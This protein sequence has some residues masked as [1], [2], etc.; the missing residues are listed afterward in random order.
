MFGTQKAVMI[1]IAVAVI[2]VVLVIGPLLPVLYQSFVDRALHQAGGQFTLENYV[3]LSQN[4]EFKEV[5]FN[6]LIFAAGSMVLAQVIGIFL[7]I[8]VG[9]TDLPM[10]GLFSGVIIWPLFLSHLLLSFGWFILYGPAGYATLALRSMIGVEPWNLYSMGGMIMIAGVSSAP[11]TALFCIASAALADPRMEDAARTAGAGPFTILTRITIPLMAPAI[12]YSAIMNFTQCLEM[13][14]IPLMFGEPAG[15]ELFMSYIYTEAFSGA[16]TNYGILGASLVVL[17]AIIGMLITF[18]RWYLSNSRRFNSVGGKASQPRLFR[19]GALRWPMFFLVLFYV[20]AFI[21]LPV[22]AV[23]LRAFVPFLSPFVPFMGSLTTENFQ[24]LWNSAASMRAIW[25]TII[26]AF[27]A[28]VLGTLL[29]AM[30]GIVVQKSNFKG[31]GAL[32][33]I[34]I[35]PRAIPGMV[36]GIGILYLMLFLP[37]IGW[38]RNTI[39]ILVIAYIAAALPVGLG[40][41]APNLM[42]ISPD[43]D[44]AARI[45]GADWWTMVRTILLRLIKPALFSSFALMFIMF[46]KE[47]TTAIFVVAPGSEVLGASI[48]QNWKQGDAAQA[49]ALA[50]VQIGMLMTFLFVARRALGVK[51]HG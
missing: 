6:S 3:K 23:I 31:R 2:T 29:A 41:I 10:R 26:I 34:A 7:A 1:Q 37:Q 44:R 36:V 43:L 12:I 21:V 4:A 48:L 18:Q 27:T 45:V 46:T 35:L 5:M 17:I 32:E 15:I 9:R 13:L 33:Y 19:L 49:A 22:G 8:L 39:W 28:G 38:L 42:Q 20:I 14:S 16:R 51:I 24:T 25:N 40:A 47:Y 50:T 11:L 30:I